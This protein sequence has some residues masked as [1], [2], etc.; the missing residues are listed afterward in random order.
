MSPHWIRVT[1][2]NLTILILPQKKQRE[3]GVR[4]VNSEEGRGE[5]GR[6][7]K[8]GRRKKKAVFSFTHSLGQQGSIQLHY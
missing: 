3:R 8:G 5:E 4:K 7:R 1:V 2:V 6:E